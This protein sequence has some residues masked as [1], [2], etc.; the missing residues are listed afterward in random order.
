VTLFFLARRSGVHDTS[1]SRTTSLT[2]RNFRPS[3]REVQVVALTDAQL[4]AE[5][6]SEA[7]PFEQLVL[8]H[9][10]A[11]HRYVARRLGPTQ[12]DDVASEVF[13]TAYAL[14]GRYD[15]TRADARPWLFGIATNL[16]RRHRRTEAQLLAAYAKTGVH[17]EF[18][19]LP[20]DDLGA[21]LASAL[22][23]MRKEH[24]DVLLL[25]TLADLTYDEIAIAMDVPIGTVRGWLNRARAVAARELAA[26]GVLPTSPRTT[27]QP[28]AAE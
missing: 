6:S 22:A 14:R 24:R 21:A 18:P 12:A 19:D 4:L 13:A 17:P 27:P 9:H 28:K 16:I 23:A 3:F 10:P 8:R 15:A 26:R 11:V 1:G 25:H 20:N 5:S 2:T 7:E